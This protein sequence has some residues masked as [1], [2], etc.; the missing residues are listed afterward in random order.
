MTQLV[1]EHDEL[2]ADHDYAAP[3]EVAGRRLHGGFLTD[4]TYQPPRTLVREPALAAWEGALRDRGGE[5]FA[6]SADLLTGPR[7]PTV[8]QQLALLRHGL[9]QPFW[10]TLTVVGKIEARGAFLS[11]LPVPDLSAAIIEDISEMA[12]GHL[13]RGLLDAHGLDEGGN[14]ALGIG[15][16]DEMWFVARDLVYGPDAHPDIEPPDNIARIDGGRHLPEIDSK[17]EELLSFL[18]NLLVIEFR[19]ELGFAE[20]QAVF[21]SPEAFTDRRPEAETAAEIIERIRTDE[22]I[23]VR[24]LNLYLGEIRNVHLRTGDGR[25]LPG[26]VLI[27][28][29]W[30]GLVHWATVEQ[31]RLAV[32]DSQRRM[33]ERI[34]REPDGDPIRAA[35]D[36]A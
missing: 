32:E 19:A 9:D 31:P 26:S 17:I 16:H 1:Y 22:R 15:G 8:P 33:Y 29:F 11:V 23:H 21:N 14:P 13:D 7:F 2:L 12:I 35:F 30:D 10:D 27:D 25:H 18:A 20:T 24:S 4:G 3:H 34:A 28:R 6:A 5:P 36:A